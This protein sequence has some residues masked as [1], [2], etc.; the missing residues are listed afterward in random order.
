MATGRGTVG[1]RGS[2]R[3]KATGTGTSSSLLNC[4][5]ESIRQ[6]SNVDSYRLALVACHSAIYKLPTRG[7][8]CPNYKRVRKYARTRAVFI[9]SLWDLY[10]PRGI[11]IS[12]AVFRYSV[13]YLYI[14]RG[15]YDIF[16]GICKCGIFH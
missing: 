14:P 4:H 5:S 12:L 1:T 8:L 3:S 16:R 2:C 7:A 11:Y 15:I 10:I 6:S 9:Y 13:R